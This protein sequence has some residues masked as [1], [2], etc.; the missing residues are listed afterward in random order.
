[1]TTSNNE[2]FIPFRG[3]LRQSTWAEEQDSSSMSDNGSIST[4]ARHSSSSRTV[5]TIQVPLL[6]HGEDSSDEAA[7]QA[8]VS[9]GYSKLVFERD[10]YENMQRLFQIIDSAGRGTLGR[11][12]MA[13]FV[14]S[15]FALAELAQPRTPVGLCFT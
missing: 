8:N 13:E 4:S 7:G 12:E 2:L 6:I 1:M 5:F 9:S 14:L 11:R 10:Q 3:A 15:T